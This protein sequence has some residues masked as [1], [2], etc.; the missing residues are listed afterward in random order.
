MAIIRGG[1][2]KPSKNGPKEQAVHQVVGP[3][4][5]D[6]AGYSASVQA[7]AAAGPQ[8]SCRPLTSEAGN[9]TALRVAFSSP[10]RTQG[11]LTKIF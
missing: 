8:T 7:R 9:R 3:Q 10:C 11:A 4:S 1:T 5:T 2:P 6:T